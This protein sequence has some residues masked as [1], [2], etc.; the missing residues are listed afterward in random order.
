MGYLSGNLFIA[1]AL[2]Q[3][4]LCYLQSC[5]MSLCVQ[6]VARLPSGFSGG[7][8]SFRPAPF[9]SDSSKWCLSASTSASAP[10]K[11]LPKAV[12]PQSA[13][14]PGNHGT[15]YWSGRRGPWHLWWQVQSRNISICKLGFYMEDECWL[16]NCEQ[17]RQLLC[18]GK[19]YLLLLAICQRQGKKMQYFI[20]LWCGSG[21]TAKG[22][23]CH[24]VSG[25]M[26][27]SYSLPSIPLL[28]HTSLAEGRVFTK[29]CLIS[30]V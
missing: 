1:G 2:R 9:L 15:E 25:Q 11:M 28:P 4:F 24:F 8:H 21:K 17:P 14:L 19:S 3:H 23:N 7:L 5:P 12:L 13:A 20:V 29:G 22:E 16:E 18:K 10:L 6:A 30:S 27:F 26:L